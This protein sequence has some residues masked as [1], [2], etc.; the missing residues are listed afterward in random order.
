MTTGEIPNGRVTLQV[1]RWQVR[2]MLR[3]RW[4]IGYT[5]FFALASDALLRMGGDPDK[6]LVSLMNVVLL[7]V[8]LV[9]TVLGTVFLY[10]ARDFTELLLAQPVPRRGLYAGLFLGLVLPLSAGLAVGLGA[11]FVLHG[12]FASGASIATCL[13]L[14]VAGIALTS[15]FAGVAFVVAL[16][17]PDRVK[18][19]GAAI[20]VWALT[21]VVYDGAVLWC[22]TIFADY[23][24]ERP[25][26]G[27]MLSNPVDL[28]R[29]VLL[30][31]FDVSALMGYTG[32]VFQQ[33]FGGA[34]GIAIASTALALWVTLP[35]AFGLR[36]FRKRDF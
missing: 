9:T 14:I 33:F 6:A 7:V 18:G 32:A 20:A 10:Q 24:V 23:P 11:P 19:L 29:I 15:C 17:F 2:D 3:S 8:P 12:A 1:A 31:R 35:V 27:V 34:L 21:A 5:L 26:V 25:L 28:A 4:L 36:A 13:T 22:A 16:R 30:L